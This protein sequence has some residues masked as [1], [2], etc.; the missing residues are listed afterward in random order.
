MRRTSII[1]NLVVALAALALS[2]CSKIYVI[3]TTETA[4]GIVFTI[5]DEDG[6]LTD[7]VCTSLVRVRERSSKAVAWEASSSSECQP[8]TSFRYGVSPQSIVTTVGPEELMSGQEYE[9]ITAGTTDASG[10][11]IKQ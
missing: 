5:S 1:S 7:P 8:L 3:R 11:F 2:S 10:T 6:P 4:G 9:V